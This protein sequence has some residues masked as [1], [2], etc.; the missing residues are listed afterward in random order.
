[1]LAK[2]NIKSVSLPPRKICSYLP[3]VKNA[4]GLRMPG[5]YSMPCECGQVYIG[6]SN[7]SIQSR[8]KEHSRHIWL[9]QTGKL[10]VSEHSINQDRIIKLQDTKLCSTKTGYM[11]QIIR[12]GTELEMHPHNMNRE[13]GLTLSKSWKLF[14]HRPKE[15]RQ[16]PETQELVH[17]HPMAPLPYSD[18]GPFLT[19]ILV[20]LQAS[21]WGSCPPPP[22][23]LLRLASSPT[24]LLLTG[25]Y[26]F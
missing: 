26:F 23:P 13:D 3:P 8:I 4:L 17:C 21:T 22:V 16:L 18:T 6:Q 14:L 15:R 19:Y 12:E 10:A 5:V 2:H 9:V 11:D 24:P 20:L 25:P 7:Q 1:M